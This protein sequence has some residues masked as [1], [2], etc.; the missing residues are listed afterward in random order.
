MMSNNCR[1]APVVNG[2]LLIEEASGE[3]SSE[4]RKLYKKGG[5]HPASNVMIDFFI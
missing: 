1:S 2:H 3:Y 5:N 4:F